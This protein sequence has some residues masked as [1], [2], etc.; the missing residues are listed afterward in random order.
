MKKFK[1]LIS[2]VLM[3]A[4]MLTLVPSMGLVAMAADT[5]V[6]K[7]ELTNTTVNVTAGTTEY[8]VPVAVT[9]PE[10]VDNY[11][12]E[13]PAVT[14]VV[15]ESGASIVFNQTTPNAITDNMT[16][17]VGNTAYTLT[18]DLIGENLYTNGG[19]EKGDWE[20]SQS[21]NTVWPISNSENGN[22]C[23]GINAGP[24]YPDW[25]AESFEADKVYLASSMI[26]LADDVVS[27]AGTV[28][29]KEEYKDVTEG[30]VV[31]QSL[32]N[33]DGTVRNDTNGFVTPTNWITHYRTYV[34]DKNGSF[35]DV[36]TR[37]DDIWTQRDFY[38][39]EYFMGEL[40]AN[41]KV[42]D[43]D[44]ADK[45]EISIPDTDTPITLT[46]ERVNQLGNQAGL[47]SATPTFTWA[48]AGP[49]ED[50]TLTYDGVTIKANATPGT[51][52][53]T[54]EAATG[55][56]GSE[57]TIAKG[58]YE[59]KIVDDSIYDATLKSL[60]VSNADIDFAYDTYNYDVKV[61][62]L[63]KG[64]K[65]TYVMPTVTAIAKNESDRVLPIEYPDDIPGNIVVTVTDG[66]KTNT[67]TISLSLL[68][69][70]RYVNGGFEEG[71]YFSDTSGA[72]SP[73]GWKDW[74][75]Y[76][77]EVSENT[78]VGNKAMQY[79]SSTT[80]KVYQ[81]APLTLDKNKVYLSS[82]MV[83]LAEHA[84]NTAESYTKSSTFEYYTGNEPST[85]TGV[86]GA[87]T[88]YETNGDIRYDPSTGEKSDS[89]TITD[90]WINMCA[91]LYGANNANI[92]GNTYN[93]FNWIMSWSPD[94][95]MLV[96]D[97]YFMGEL[98]IA[99]IV[100]TADKAVLLPSASE[101]TVTLAAKAVNNIGNLAGIKDKVTLTYRLGKDAPAG[102]TINAAGL[103]TVP[104]GYRGEFEV[105]AVAVPTWAD[106][107]QDNYVKAYTVTV[108]DTELIFADDAVSLKFIG[109]E[110]IY[111]L[112][113]AVY[114]VVGGE[115]KFVDASI[116]DI[117]KTSDDYSNTIEVE[118]AEGQALKTFFWKWDD[119]TPVVKSYTFY[120]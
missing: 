83:R 92:I 61:P 114:D 6:A 71:M 87:A 82:S 55:I 34:L 74:Y 63:H 107:A 76:Y 33:S 110:G 104:A 103:V 20:D 7:I 100:F 75:D 53:V 119:L 29:H 25:S 36:Y 66:T 40:V 108:G 89:Y 60:K 118:L 35:A 1:T 48:V 27:S 38:T 102:A 15:A 106:A 70:N 120:K 115:L 45:K 97:D 46:A 91:T 52:Y 10:N 24:Y 69:E 93:V 77:T 9:Y 98:A 111:R 22:Y 28:M 88:W 101:Q 95:P 90:E 85:S 39:D 41:I 65:D 109:D 31:T 96:H 4:M 113:T 94:S 116:T 59:I 62:V 26:R 84:N 19:A 67:Y 78:A 112:V 54:A 99:D 11:T 51:Y 56:A 12:Y 2:F 18:F 5:T 57:Q 73:I 80:T 21:G 64:E 8:T 72:T 30:V 79:K 68:G 50:V 58:S 49:S 47:G 37:W 44:N 81:S 3:A 32:W 13:I 16:V 105:E 42:T 17:T 14:K 43:S 23:I 86:G 117:T